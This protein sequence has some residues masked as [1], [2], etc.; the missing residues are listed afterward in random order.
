M[1]DIG[2]FLSDLDTFIRFKTCVDQNQSEFAAARAWIRDFFDS[3]V[4][5]FE[6]FAYNGFTSLLIKPLV[7]E[8][9][10]LL[11]DGHIEVVPGGSGLFALRQKGPLLFG[12]GVADMKTQCL[13]MMTVLRDMLAENKAFDFWLLFSEDEEIGSARG[14]QQMIM[15]LD[16]RNCIPEVVFVPDGGPNF[17]YVEKEKGMISFDVK[18]LGQSAHGSRPFLG[19][20]AIERM[21]AL[22]TDFQ[23][24]FPNPIE[25]S[26]WV[27]SLSITSIEGGQAH[28]QIPDQCRA[29]FDLRF[30]EAF[31]P[32]EIVMALEEIS[33][34]YDAEI[35]FREIGIATYYP[36][37]R[38]VAR[39]YI[40]L[41]RSVSEREP[42]I[43][44]SNGASN[45]RF[46][47]MQKPEVQILMS[48]PTVVDAHAATECLDARSLP[49]FYR[50][51]H[52]TVELICSA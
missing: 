49:A 30:T 6:V 3:S 36:R 16:S 22:Y 20:N 48:N 10:L 15:L 26:E 40:D 28:N 52:D 18:I 12:R 33:Q 42:A 46:Y 45:A 17:A 7:S 38:P 4:T 11:G 37:E 34:P 13:M 47:V 31:T 9:P 24:R 21:Q 25:E 19:I 14:A 8:R 5:D 2:R 41:L 23:A 32:E 43:L 44:H 35:T 39:T 1:F 27:P 50:L 51:V 29:G